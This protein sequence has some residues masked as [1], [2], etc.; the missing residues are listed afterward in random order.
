MGNRDH[1]FHLQLV[2]VTPDDA[3]AADR[4]AATKAALGERLT[5]RTYLNGLD[6]PARHAAAATS[7]DGPDRAAIAAVRAELD[8]DDVLRYGVDHRR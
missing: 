6:G 1:Q 2:A 4:L 7:I 8:P 5:S 3:A